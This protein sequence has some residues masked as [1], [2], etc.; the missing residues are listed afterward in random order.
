VPPAQGC[1]RDSLSIIS[2]LQLETPAT[3]KVIPVFFS[4]WLSG[5][6]SLP[7]GAGRGGAAEIP[8]E[9]AAASRCARWECSKRAHARLLAR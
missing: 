3:G 8:P 4:S 6:E 2:R 9:N 5:S 7:S 1:A